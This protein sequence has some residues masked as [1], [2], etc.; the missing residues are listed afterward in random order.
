MCIVALKDQ[1]I[2][3]CSSFGSSFLFMRK[4]TTRLTVQVCFGTNSLI[5]MKRATN[6]IKTTSHV[7]TYFKRSTQEL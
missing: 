5:L 7:A 2:W 1:L 6:R 3:D 4:Y